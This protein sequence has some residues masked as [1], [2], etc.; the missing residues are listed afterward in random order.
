MDLQGC[1]MLDLILR[2]ITPLHFKAHGA[3]DGVEAREYTRDEHTKMFRGSSCKKSRK[4][5]HG[6]PGKEG[7]SVMPSVFVD[8]DRT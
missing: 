1:P 3:K 6:L 8:M 4:L 7:H 2:I 5:V